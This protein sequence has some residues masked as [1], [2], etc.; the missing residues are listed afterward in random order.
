MHILIMLRCAILS[1]HNRKLRCTVVFYPDDQKHILRIDSHPDKA[2]LRVSQLFHTLYCIVKRIAEY[3]ETFG[4]LFIADI[5]SFEELHSEIEKI[6]I[7]DKLVENWTYP[8]IQPIL[9]EEAKKRGFI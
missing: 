5:N 6:L 4:M 1:V 8:L 9:I 7:S 2:L 3:D